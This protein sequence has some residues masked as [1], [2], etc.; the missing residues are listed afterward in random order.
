[1]DRQAVFNTLAADVAR[2]ELAF[3]TSA[4]V[5][6][7]LRQT[8]EDPECHIEAA[9]RLI[10][11]EPL[12]AARVV[13]MANSIAYN[14]SGR[15]IA[16]VR[17]AVARLGFRTVRTLAAALIARQLAGIPTDQALRQWASQ[18]WEHTAHV[19][20]LAHVLARRITHVDVET[21][22]FA[23]IVHEVAGFYLLSRAQ[24]FPGLLEGDRVEWNEGGAA[25]VGTA[26]LKLLEVPAA[27]QEGIQAYWDGY[28][29]IPPESLGDT[30][31]L[32]EHLSPVPSPLQT[33]PS[34]D[35]PPGLPA[36]LDMA[37]GEDTLSSILE[38]SAAEVAS[39]TGALTF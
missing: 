3:P 9:T 19:A 25:T 17:T 7:K 23:G 33:P 2:G 22:L 34:P 30:L 8:L 6:M 1:M 14:R 37:I 39:L 4:R 28:L 26:I 24:E 32:A 12:L 15:E 16:D 31:L 36:N 27:V 20:S 5:A 35:A 38:E 13:A 29:A 18:L 10:Q 11:A 21:A